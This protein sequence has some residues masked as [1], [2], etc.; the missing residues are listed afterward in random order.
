MPRRPLWRLRS[1]RAIARVAPGLRAKRAPA[2]VLALGVAAV[3]VAYPAAMAVAA[4][5]MPDVGGLV[6]VVC[7]LKLAERLAR[8]LA[9]RQGHDAR[10]EPMI[11]RVAL[12][13]ALTLYAMFAFRRWYAFAAAG[14][15]VMLALEVGSIAL[16]RGARFRWRDAVAAAALGA[17][18]LLALLSP[19]L[20]DWAPNLSAHD[21][22]QTYAGY[23][24]PPDVFLR[25]LGDWV[26]LIP[27]LA[28]L[29][30]AAF[31]WTRS[32]DTRLL[33]LTLGAAAIAAALFLRIQTPYIHHLDLIA[34]AIVV[35]VAASLMLLFA[36]RAARRASRR[37]RAWRDHA[38]AVGGGA[39][40][41]GPRA[42]R[43]IA[44]RAARRPRRTRAPQGL[45]RSARAARRQGL[46]PRLE[47][48]VQRPAHR[49]I[50]AASPGA[51]S[52]RE[53]AR[54]SRC[55]T[56]IRSTGRRERL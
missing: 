21:Y 27:A 55:R 8:L 23:R 36:Q 26:G 33:R 19:V 42:D 39:Q 14:I 37:G 22:A 38:L 53:Q 49:R 48:Y 4:R 32:R 31:L 11:R 7:A 46:R 3:F 24:K 10:V 1:W 6:L 30:G 35:P 44:A 16:R 13:L 15:V 54:A 56:S 40:S 2:I 47:L 29:A 43:R 50:V 34:P 51:G 52:E 20:V 12:A 18:T 5:G 45:G 41:V 17:L 28:A 25:E 9:L